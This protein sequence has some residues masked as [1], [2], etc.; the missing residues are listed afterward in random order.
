MLISTNWLRR[1]VD[2]DGV[3][4]DRLADS[5]VLSV[6]EIEEV[7]PVGRGLEAVVV[8]H[9]LDVQ[10]IAG[11][12]IRVTRVDCGPAGVRQIVC[13]APNVAV[14][15]RVP[16]VLPGARLGDVVVEE[17]EVRGVASAGMIASE[18][19][20]GLTDDH[21]G[22]MVLEGEPAPGTR[23]VDVVD[24][25]DTLFE[26]DN[27]SLTHRPDLWGHRG[28]A[29]EVAALL[30]RPLLPMPLEIELGTETPLA[31]RVDDPVACP[32]Y[33]AVC[34]EGV[35]VRPSPLWLRLLLARVGTRAISNVVDATNFVMLDLGNP[36][37]AFDRRHIRGDAI[38]VRRALGG[39]RF[40]TLDGE[41][42]LLDARDLLI[43]DGERG[44][45]LA[46]VMGGLNSEIVPD[47]TAVVL[48]SASFDAA[49]VRMTGQRLGLRTESSTRFEKSLDP[50]L[51]EEASRSFCGLL[52]QLD[53]AVR[54]TSALMDVAAPRPPLPIIEL[55][56]ARVD[57]A[58]G[59][60]V[61]QQRMVEI[62]RRL[63]FGVEITAPGR[64]SVRVPTFR[65]TK[66]IA[67]EAD[68]VEEIGRTFGYGNIAPTGPTIQ[69][70]RP[71]R[72]E[73]KRLER[74]VR[75]TL[76]AGYGFDEV[77]THSF[78]FDPFLDR[79]GAR[80][81]RRV[82]LRNAIS[83]EMPA[84]R[85]SLG[86]QLLA[87]LD[88][89]ARREADVRVFELGRVFLPLAEPAKG[90]LPDQPTRLGA[91]IATT[92]TTATTATNATNA[93]TAAMSG[94]SLFFALKA[95][96]EGLGGAMRRPA[97]G[98]RQGGVDE[99]FA[100]P[101]RQATLLL[102]ER[103][104]GYLAEVHPLTLR[105]LDVR[106]AAAL[107]EVDLDAWRAADKVDDPYQPLPR[108]PAANRDFAVVVP[109]PVA[110]GDAAAAIM[111]AAPELIRDVAFQ[112]VYTG[113]GVPDD[114]KC[115]AW[116]VTLRH[117]E[118][119]LTEPEIRDAEQAV[120]AALAERVGGVPR[121]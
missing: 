36:L 38:V 70:R 56:V 6:A 5:F 90:E 51:A 110:A 107:F 25:E 106:H 91:L 108:L 59:A 68:L 82:T 10:P 12:K 83:A 102:G 77:M 4:L 62:L 105:Q 71:D 85:T 118:R 46:G 13:G 81:E 99:V 29:R 28:I 11:A 42:R 86:P 88:K 65:A 19:E 41:E 84:L 32:R 52:R 117:D 96:L 89:N 45:A 66:D 114:H 74:R 64:L 18:A 24:V 67:I 115:L 57:R 49:T 16:V 80:P 43:A 2:L 34:L 30:D 120:W 53:P 9:V 17:R 48:E 33:T 60:P 14:G 22:I 21:V 92:A 78:G 97:I 112:S 37:H 75:T 3:D 1:H 69:L 8:G 72:N 55:R 121:A 101:A 93:T 39:E 109:L 61:G 104:V 20:L 40:T 87:V 23:M 26:I 54:V 15:Q 100:H 63:E 7:R 79:I 113:R 73:R 31:V 27:K 95:V 47:T 50:V 35:T 94:T 103:A 58:L 111:D 44:V 119:T 116:S 98:F 76:A